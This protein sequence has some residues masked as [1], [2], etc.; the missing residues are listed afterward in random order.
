MGLQFDICVKSF[1]LFS[2]ESLTLAKM[3]RLTIKQ[4]KKIIKTYYRNCDPATVTY[5]TLRGD[6]G[7]HNRSTM[8]TIGKIVKKFEETGEVTNI[9]RPVHHRSACSTENMAIEGESVAKDPNVLISSRSQEFRT[10]LRHIIPY[11]AF[12][13]T[14]TSI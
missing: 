9:E 1:F 2:I 6:Y 12:R 13:S 14:P 4:S 3:D 8:Q 11:F 5:R 7:L 10:V